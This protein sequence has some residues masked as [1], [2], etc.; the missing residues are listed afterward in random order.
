MAK[1][2][3]LHANQDSGWNKRVKLWVAPSEPLTEDM[4]DGRPWRRLWQLVL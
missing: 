4:I 1:P 3:C 2:A